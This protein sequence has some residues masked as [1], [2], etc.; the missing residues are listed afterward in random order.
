VVWA[1]P[2]GYRDP[3]LFREFWK[4]VEHYRVAAMS[5]VPTVYGALA[6]RPSTPT[7][8]ACGIRWWAPRR[9]PPQ[10]GT[11]SRPPPG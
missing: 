2:L 1:G 6:Q 4:I 7:S 3:A 5:A 11:A 9:C 8:A 10:S